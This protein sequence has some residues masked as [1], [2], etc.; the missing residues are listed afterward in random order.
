M[1]I[2]SQASNLLETI[3]KFLLAS[4]RTIIVVAF[5]IAALFALINAMI[6]GPDAGS[7]APPQ[8]P[9]KI[10]ELSFEFKED[11]ISKNRRLV[12]EQKARDDFLAKKEASLELA[13][14]ETENHRKDIR[15]LKGQKRGLPAELANK[16]KGSEAYEKL[17]DEI[18]QI[19]K[20]IS[21]RCGEAASNIEA[22][23]G[24]LVT[25]ASEIASK[26]GVKEEVFGPSRTIE[27]TGYADEVEA[28]LSM[29]RAC[30]KPV[31]AELVQ[32]VE[33]YMTAFP[34]NY[35]FTG[36][37]SADRDKIQSYIDV[38]YYRKWLAEYAEL[39]SM[40]DAILAAGAEYDSLTVNQSIY[41]K[42]DDVWAQLA[43]RS[44][45]VARHYSAIISKYEKDDTPPTNEEYAAISVE[46]V[47]TLPAILEQI[48]KDY[49]KQIAANN[50]KAADFKRVKQN[51]KD[52]LVSV[53]YTLLL[54]IGLIAFL[55][56]LRI[57]RNVRKAE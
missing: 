18:D 1:S 48:E 55:S 53:R 45:D 46:I 13:R 10:N 12:Q 19:E 36:Q 4:S 51:A 31:V 20:S 32:I 43:V 42:I 39:Q 27:K 23:T 24:K 14:N 15:N 44:G 34:D 2:K 56:Y 6:Y 52:V 41:W 30:P 3:E 33:N 54:L 25:E 57:E 26:Y 7:Q 21:A 35:G 50:K 22:E 16:V 11:E 37:G 47:A 49:N 8:D 29:D 9:L 40:K 28:G 38:N 5:F 17:A